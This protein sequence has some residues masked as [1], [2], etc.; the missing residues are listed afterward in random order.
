MAI[1]RQLSAI[2]PW[3]TLALTLL[4]AVAALS[5]CGEPETAKPGVQ[6]SGSG[7][8]TAV[9]DS[10]G[11]GAVRPAAGFWLAELKSPGG[12]LPFGLILEDDGTNI[13]GTLVN[14][15]EKIAIPETN[16]EDGELTLFFPH[17]DSR[18]VAQVSED[19]TEFTGDWSKRR[20]V[21]SWTNMTFAARRAGD[22]T[23]PN[24]SSESM[25]EME[26][27]LGRWS[28][29]F[30]QSKDPAVA[31][32]QKAE[33]GRPWGTFLT[34]TGDYRFLSA[35]IVDGGRP[36]TGGDAGNSAAE[37][38]APPMLRMSVFDGAHA[39]LFLARLSEAG[40]IEGDFWSSDTW[41]ETWTATR[42]DS[43][44]LPNGFQQ[45]KWDA[46][47]SLADLVFPDLEGNRVSLADEKF[48]GKARIVEVFGTWCPNCHD[49]AAY[50]GELDAKYGPRGLSIVGVAFEHTGDF[51]RDVQQV[52]RY[53]DR[54][55]VG[56]PVLLAGLSDK[57][58]ATKAFSA[59]DRIRSY[60]TTIFMHAN[61]RVRAV[62]SGFSGP[63]TGEE[64][65]AL[66]DEFEALIEEL[67]NEE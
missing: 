9:E 31:V 11:S 50:L 5:G 28:V 37:I 61:G 43:A 60:P 62:Y 17:Y 18:I 14:G 15:P 53:I 56:Y 2:Q 67:L 34:T 27:Y 45:T 23:P 12:T 8:A 57:T 24:T 38:D 48:A 13:N 19:G 32:L 22:D 39:F 46:S 21:E 52:K 42:D 64:Y 58:Q 59:L 35:Q 54:H 3:P 16:Y 4:A 29:R 25:G 26:R 41:R 49:A 10:D 20:S 51:Q 1:E 66:R 63:A 65:T 33:D 36:Q 40:E 55:K 6:P 47:I 44:S 30:A 7:T